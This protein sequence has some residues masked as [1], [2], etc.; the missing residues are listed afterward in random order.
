[1]RARVVAILSRRAE[2]PEAL[3]VAILAGPAATA[4]YCIALRRRITPPYRAI[5]NA[6]AARLTE[7]THLFAVPFTGAGELHEDGVSREEAS[8]E[9]LRG[10]CAV[11]DVRP[12]SGAM[13][14]TAGSP[15]SRWSVGCGPLE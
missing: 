6:L 10:V 9:R 1:M 15:A 4:N 7:L 13:P 11:S 5:L 3:A 2:V 8:R 12:A 14:P